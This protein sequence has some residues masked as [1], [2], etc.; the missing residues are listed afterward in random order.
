M[1]EKDKDK[2]IADLTAQTLLLSE[3]N[4]KLRRE[5]EQ[6][7]MLNTVYVEKELESDLDSFTEEHDVYTEELRMGENY[8]R[9]GY[10]Y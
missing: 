7:Q 5:L 8:N 3:D 2:L 1:T 9:I 10:D 4:F 6:A